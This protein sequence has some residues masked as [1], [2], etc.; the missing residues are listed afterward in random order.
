MEALCFSVGAGV[1]SLIG[2]PLTAQVISDAMG[3]VVS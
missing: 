1:K 2:L 3:D